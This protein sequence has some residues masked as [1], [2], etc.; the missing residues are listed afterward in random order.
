MSETAGDDVPRDPWGN[1]LPPEDRA[2]AN[3]RPDDYPPTFPTEGSTPHEPSPPAGAPRPG[4][5]EA[6]AP[7]GNP[8]WPGRQTPPPE[9]PQASPRSEPPAPP[10]PVGNPSWPGSA[11]TTEPPPGP[12][13]PTSQGPTPPGNPTWP[14]PQGPGSY[15]EGPPPQ[16]WVPGAPWGPPR[17]DGSAIGA[18]VCGILSITCA[19]YLGIILGPVALVLGVRSRRRITDSGGALRGEGMAQAGIVLG[20]IGIVISIAS[21]VFILMNPDFVTDLLDRLTTT[22]TTTGS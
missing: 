11:P 12:D 19:G 17:N 2:P 6:A 16:G 4:T 22:T 1:P 14:A 20:I 9:A 7:T 5:P 18:L 3:P 15:P 8:A 10:P 21:L 13:W